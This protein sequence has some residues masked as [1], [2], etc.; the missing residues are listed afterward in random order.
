[1]ASRPQHAGVVRDDTAPRSKQM[2]QGGDHGCSWQKGELEPVA[3]PR[4]VWQNVAERGSTTPTL[5]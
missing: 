5:G 1:M 2:V 3:E 4:H